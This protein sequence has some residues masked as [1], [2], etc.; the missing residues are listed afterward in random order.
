MVDPLDGTTNFSLGLHYWGVS[1]AYLLDG[2]PQAAALYFPLINE[3]YTAQAGQGAELNGTPLHLTGGDGAA[4]NQAES[5][6]R[7]VRTHPPLHG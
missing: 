5:F 3:M 1:L 7:A 6:F 4:P 2:V